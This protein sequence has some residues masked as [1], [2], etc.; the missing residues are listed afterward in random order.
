LAEGECFESDVQTQAHLVSYLRVK[1]VAMDFSLFD[2]SAD[3]RAWLSRKLDEF[4]GYPW[5]ARIHLAS[6]AMLVPILL[7]SAGW[8]TA[9]PVLSLCALVVAHG[10]MLGFVV[11]AWPIVRAQ[12]GSAVGSGVTVALHLLAAVFSAAVARNQVSVAIGLPGQDFDLTVSLLALLLYLPAWSL[13]LSI[14]LAPS[15]LVGFFF[16]LM[17]LAFKSSPQDKSLFGLAHV[18]GAMILSVHAGQFFQWS[19]EDGPV[20]TNIIRTVA[21]YADYQPADAYPG[22]GPLDRIRLH[23]NGVVSCAVHSGG[24]VVIRVWEREKESSPCGRKVRRN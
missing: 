12:A 4:C 11:W 7:A 16:L 24:E 22:V 15:Y 17:R 6:F 10:F 2:R 23:E 14:L 13:I 20:R 8:P 9:R 1:L 3:L 19:T 5:F 21:L 18:M